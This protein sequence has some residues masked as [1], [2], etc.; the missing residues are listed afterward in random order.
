MPT[1]VDPAAS[2]SRSIQSPIIRCQIA[3]EVQI[4][5]LF[6][7]TDL[8]P[9]IRNFVRID[10][11]LFRRDQ[12]AAIS[13]MYQEWQYTLTTYYAGKL[14]GGNS[15]ATQKAT[16]AFGGALYCLVGLDGSNLTLGTSP[17]DSTSVVQVVFPS[18][19]DQ[20]VVTGDQHGGLLIPAGTLTQPVTITISPVPG[21]YTA[22]AGPLNTKLDQYGPFFEFNV[23]PAQTFATPVIAAGCIQGL[24][25]N[26]RPTSVDMAHNVGTG[27]EIL[28]TVPAQ[29]LNCSPTAEMLRQPSTMQLARNGDYGRALGR[30][31]RA[32]VKAFSPEPAYAL[33]S[34][35]IGGK[36]T[37]F[38][39]FGGVDTAVVVKLPA[40]FPAQPQT[41]PA[42]S[43]VASAPSVLVQ[44]ASGTP[45][46][47]ASVVFTIA[48][49]GGS[50]GPS[51]SSS[52]V[53]ATTLTTDSATGVAA[54]PSWTLGVGSANTMNAIASFALP[55]SIS[56]YPTTAKSGKPA[57]AFSGNP[58]AFTAASTDVIAY[59]ATGYL[60]LSGNDGLA[61]GFESPS[62]QATAANGWQTGNAAFASSNLSG[63]CASLAPTVGT[64]WANVPSGS[65]Y[66]DMLLRR[67]FTL[68]AWWTSGFTMGMAIDNDFQVFI[69]GVNITPTNIPD[70]NASSGF[71]QHEGCATIDSYTFPVTV[72]GGTHVLAIR[73]RDRGVVAYVDTRLS[74][75]P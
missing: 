14:R 26:L 19:A 2:A 3:S 75:R 65:P 5:A 38:S 70:Y 44:T 23:V 17:L 56:G 45:L 22:P 7:P 29:F 42:G 41:A 67:T 33:A 68:P 60:Y 6:K 62:Y 54:V 16:L 20:T 69:D 28:P 63:S 53:S 46:G 71:V 12:T 61:Q 51:S 21:T 37:S 58:V 74:P 47:G 25:G 55:T 57:I 35:G 66:T 31:A 36:T 64:T 9:A 4:I 10:A 13:D 40:T 34:S 43:A 49:G 30:L 24:N 8:G 27:I 72:G 32:T 52:V 48:P 15:A 18:G 11:E 73:A 1:A 50:L 39:P 59:G